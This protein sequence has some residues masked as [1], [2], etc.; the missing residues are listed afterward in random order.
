VSTLVNS[1]TSIH[2]RTTS[3]A[4]GR[5]IQYVV[6]EARPVVQVVFLMRLAAATG[7]L[8]QP[9]QRAL[10]MVPGWLLLVV[11][12]YVFNGITDVQGDEINGSERPIASGRLTQASARR[13]CVG[14]SC[15][16]LA[17]CGL[18]S[19]SELALG[20]VLLAIGWA[21]SAGPSF[22]ST[23]L[24]LE[25]SVG[26]GAALTYTAGWVVRGS[27][28]YRSLALMLA[29]SGW[30]GLCCVTK[31][32]SDVEGDRVAGRRTLPVMLGQKRAAV[33]VATTAVTGGVA[34]L[35]ASIWIG[36][37]FTTAMLIASGSVVLASVVLTSAEAPGR[38]T[39]RRPYRA[40]MA[41]QYA[42]NIALICAPGA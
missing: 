1:G 37:W 26:C 5:Q 11:A 41:T 34:V 25:I 18:V 3:W 8:W 9:S 17:M 33:V 2:R 38:S 42:A 39:R 32:F 22:K 36:A 35:T 31:D 21:Y 16:G 13:W 15:C 19:R 10:V 4:L 23:P 30:V 40:F 14:L 12:I 28:D 20:G 27:G 7:V 24:G 6:A 29:L